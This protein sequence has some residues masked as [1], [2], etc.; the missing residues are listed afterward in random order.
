MPEDMTWTD[1]YGTCTISYAGGQWLGS[2]TYTS[3]HCIDYKEC[4]PGGGFGCYSESSA[5]VTVPVAFAPDGA[6]WVD[7]VDGWLYDGIRDVKINRYADCSGVNHCQI[8]SDNAQT[9]GC[10]TAATGNGE[11]GISVSCATS[12][13][14]I[15]FTITG[16]L[17]SYSG[18]SCTVD[19]LT[20]DVTIT[21][22]IT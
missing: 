16:S 4:T 17:F 18:G 15:A 8:L 2:Y 10:V 9:N 11:S 22:T 21:G 20:T 3:S 6:T 14:S 13:V 19:E 7:C 1:D 5:D 12:S